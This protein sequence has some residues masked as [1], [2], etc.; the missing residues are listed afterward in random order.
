MNTRITRLFFLIGITALAGALVTAVFA[1]TQPEPAVRIETASPLHPTF[2]L[3]DTDGINVLVSGQAIS[4]MQTCGNCHD[5]TFIAEH[6][7]HVDAGLTQMSAPG[8]VPGGRAWDT[9]AGYFGKWDP[10]TYRYLSP[11]GDTLIDLT[12]AEWIQAFGW[13]HVGGGPEE[14]SRE[15][16]LL[17]DLPASVDDVET[18]IIDP[19]TGLPIVWKWDESGV[20]EMNCFLCHTPNPNNEARVAALEAG[21]FGWA[22]TATL[23]GTGIVEQVGDAWQYNAAAFDDAGNLLDSYINV[24]DP[25]T[26]NCGACHGLTHTDNVTP[27]IFDPQDN[28]LWSTLTTGQVMSPQ[29]LANSGLNLQDKDD[30]SRTWDVHTERALR[31][32]NC[33]YALNN[34]VYYRPDETDTPEHLTFD[35]RRLDF[36]EYLFRPIHEFAK[37]QSTQS[38]LAP[39]YDNT[40]RRCES[41]HSIETT[42]D[43]LPYKER[44][45]TALACETC[46]IPQLYAPALQSVDWTVLQSDGSPRREFRGTDPEQPDLITGY[47][48]VL[49]PRPTSNNET[50]LA[51]FNLVS[52][53]YWVSGDPARPV[54]LRTLQSAWFSGDTYASE[55]MVAFDA[56]QDGALDSAELLIDTPEKEAVIKARLAALGLENPR[57]VGETQP[58]SINH[59]VTYGEWA[60]RDCDTCHSADSRVAQPLVL[61]SNLPGGI[62]PTLIGNFPG[63]T[64]MLEDGSVVFQPDHQEISLY[65]LGYDAVD[66]IDTLG[67]LMF[68]GVLAGVVLHGGLRYF[69]ARRR[70]PREVELKRVYMYTIYERQW[71]WLQTI[72]IFILLFTGLVI[73]KPDQF[74]LFSFPFVVEVHNLMAVILLVNAALAAFYHLA[75]GEIRQFLPEPHGFFDQA[76]KQAIYYL[77]GI[78]RGEEHPYE[79]S[80]QRKMNPLQQITYLAILNILLPLQIITG[81]LMWGAQRWPEISASLGGLPFLAPVHS[82][83]AWTFAAFI[84]LHVYLTTTAGHTPVAGI[85]SMIMGWD[86]LEV[87]PHTPQ[88]ETE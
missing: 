25:R 19:E 11:E 39:E 72:V 8:S 87:H 20:V 86:D 61:T 47:Q 52:A 10:I 30:L 7:F 36:G 73:H 44:H 14:Y 12:T 49:L 16:T 42:H 50:A 57:I 9:S 34:P 33:H 63:E 46:H 75:S 2:A 26:E 59:D 65:V 79:K 88:P 13:R 85:Q 22:N 41:C 82:L 54:P 29:R 15:G 21:A 64:L 67:A 5:T 6:S 4:T 43:W 77:R 40:L 38:S 35:P 66:L 24:Q 28:Q 78:F 55:I 17:S 1:Q 68:L 48:P 58:Y 23:L 80:R 51:P 27:L 76:F 31:C 83:V 84:V 56:N 60:T 71:H 69:A 53:W 70:A 45:T 74:G 81:A 37:G 62:S 32:T 18:S 3:L